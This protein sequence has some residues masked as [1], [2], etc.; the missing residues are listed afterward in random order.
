MG[1][2][3]GPIVFCLSVLYLFQ[4]N[5]IA[6]ARM[7]SQDSLFVLHGLFAPQFFP[8]YAGTKLSPGKFNLRLLFFLLPV[9]HCQ[10][11]FPVDL[12]RIEKSFPIRSLSRLSAI[13]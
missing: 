4:Q 2:E 10:I 8:Y 13:H 12:R 3:T 7:A 1:S 5:R 9:K 11:L 6:F